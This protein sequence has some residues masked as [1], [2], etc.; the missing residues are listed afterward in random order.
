MRS[1]IRLENLGDKAIADKIVSR[2]NKITPISN[3]RIDLEE[4]HISFDC[5]TDRCRMI[6]AKT[7]REFS[8]TSIAH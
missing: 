2:L 4:L 3:I 5:P 1:F 6:A 8:K 7:L